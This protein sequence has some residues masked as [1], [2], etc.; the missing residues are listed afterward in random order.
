[1]KGKNPLFLIRC[2]RKFFLPLFFALFLLG[3]IPILY[4]SGYV[5][6]TGDDYGY[7]YRAHLAWLETH[8]LSETFRKAAYT[9]R[10]YWKG[11]QG[12]WFTIF[13]MALQP[14]VFSPDA[15]WIVP[16]LMLGVTVGSTSLLLHYFLR[17]R[18]A[19]PASVF[20]CADALLLTA[21][22]QFFPSTKSGIFWYNGTVH[23]IVPYGLALIAVYCF[24]RFA[25]CGKLRYFLPAFLCMAC[26]GGASYLAAL[27]A[28]IVLVYVLAGYAKKNRRVFWLLVPLAAELAGLY[29]SMTA[30]GNKNRG[31]E[32]FGFSLGKAALTVLECFAEGARCAW[33]Y[34]FEKP[35]A[36]LLLL[37]A[38][39][40]IYEGFREQE[41]I[42]F[43]FRCPGLFFLLMYA[44]WCAMFAPAL[45]AGVEV[46][47]GVPNTI[48]QIFLLTLLAAAVYAAGW[49]AV[50]RKERA[51]DRVRARLCLMLPVLFAASL[52]V[53]AH[54]GTLKETACYV[55]YAF[56]SSGEAADYRAQMEERLEIL[57]DPQI[58]EARLP[59][60]NSEQ[61]PLMHMEVL[62]DPEGWTNG[63]V[64]D[65]YGKDSVVQIPRENGD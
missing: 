22:I 33:G 13:L 14:E 54:K 51:Y 10:I 6:A 42:A 1:M 55:S 43:S 34:L 9:S 60:M 58:R 52:W 65:F 20:W 7:G 38:V 18:L 45:Y 50:K 62:E 49:A 61:G 2:D 28:P 29:V 39:F 11:W 63:V 23:Y 21:M 4:L 37:V 46:S 57:L 64:R 16:W 12:T 41:R 47:G 40:L 53:F 19:L 59:A 31:G 15:Y 8:S 26:L 24:F 32:D 48:W 25:D 17:Q 56:L 36:L 35:A 3:L 27:L 30:P 44:T 5:H